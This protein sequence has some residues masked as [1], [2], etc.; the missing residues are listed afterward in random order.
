MPA[1]VG[2]A[3]YAEAM[4]R[5]NFIISSH[6]QQGVNTVSIISR[7][8]ANYATA[9]HMV[10]NGLGKRPEIVWCKAYR[11]GILTNNDIMVQCEYVINTGSDG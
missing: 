10:K 11:E 2:D 8:S 9:T 5:L 3:R 1:S 4:V 6:L 7:F